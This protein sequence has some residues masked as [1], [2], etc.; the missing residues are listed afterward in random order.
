MLTPGR[1]FIVEVRK[2]TGDK[3][4]HDLCSLHS[5]HDP[6]VLLAVLGC[7]KSQYGERNVRMVIVEGG[8]TEVVVR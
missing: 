2:E 4:W 6:S 7:S 3:R 8:R 1:T 5:P